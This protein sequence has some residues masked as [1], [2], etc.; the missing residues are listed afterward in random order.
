MRLSYWI[1]E[2]IYVMRASE[3]DLE[4]RFFEGHTVVFLDVANADHF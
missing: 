4:S 2:I 3:R 1:V